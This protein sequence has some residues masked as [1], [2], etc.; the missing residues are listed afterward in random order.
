M[1]AAVWTRQSNFDG[2]EVSLWGL[3]R[4]ICDVRVRSASH[5]TATKSLRC[6]NRRLGAS[7]DPCTGAKSRDSKKER[8]QAASA[9]LG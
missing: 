6:T 9:W 4:P 1:P 8:M 7:A 5:P 3:E 2:R